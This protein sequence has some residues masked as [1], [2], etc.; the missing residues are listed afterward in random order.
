MFLKV[1]V[2]EDIFFQSVSLIFHVRLFIRAFLVLVTVPYEMLPRDRSLFPPKRTR[3]KVGH[4]FYFVI[5]Q[6]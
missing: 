4:L 6:G 2:Y 1:Y 3:G 5:L